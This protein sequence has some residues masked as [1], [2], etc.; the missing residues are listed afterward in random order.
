MISS[1]Y[2]RSKI[3]I[4]KTYISL[5][6]SLLWLNPQLETLEEEMKLSVR[7]H[8]KGIDF[9]RKTQMQERFERGMK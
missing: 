8:L 5:H 6:T 3:H 7:E 4:Q 1:S 9:R 2:D